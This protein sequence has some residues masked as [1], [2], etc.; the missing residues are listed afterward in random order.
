MDDVAK[1][2]IYQDELSQRDASAA[3]EWARPLTTEQVTAE[4]QTLQD[5]ADF[6]QA[7]REELSRLE[8]GNEILQDRIEATIDA[9]LRAMSLEDFAKTLEELKA[10]GESASSQDKQRL[11]RAN[12]E[13]T[14][15]V[16][17]MDRRLDAAL[18]AWAQGM[19]EGQ[20]HQTIGE[21]TDRLTKSPSAADQMMLSA[22]KT[23]LGLRES[24]RSVRRIDAQGRE[25]T[26][27]QLEQQAYA[28]YVQASLDALRGNIFS[29]LT[30]AATGD[31]ELAKA[32]G[33]A[34]GA[35]GGM[36]KGRN[37]AK[38]VRPPATGRDTGAERR[39]GLH[40]ASRFTGDTGGKIRSSSLGPARS[41]GLTAKEAAELMDCRRNVFNLPERPTRSNSKLVGVLVLESGERLPIHS[42]RFGGPWGGTHRGHIPRG[43]GSGFTRHTATHVEG[44]AA[45]IMHE[46]GIKKAT[47]LIEKMPCAACD[48]PAQR[49]NI[50]A[51]LPADAELTVVDPD[52]AS[53]FRSVQ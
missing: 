18:Q 29:V 28:E 11:E 33:E 24:D 21:L 5:K 32:V 19:P 30:F 46:R 23:E 47:L 1:R 52:A 25:G 43:E 16:E 10:K 53:T 40:E 7:T 36:A 8:H 48:N 26:E 44:H 3:A 20:L 12:V 31:P 22:A 37:E 9:E 38:A 35:L 15:R 42:G 49:P 2:D 6:G 13:L 50:T 14:R 45:A 17:D 4:L 41:D 39:A 34:M 51:M 27:R